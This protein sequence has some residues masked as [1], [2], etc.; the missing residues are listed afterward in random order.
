M[1]I[2]LEYESSLHEEAFDEGVREMISVHKRRAEQ[3]DEKAEWEKEEQTRKE[4]KEQDEE[5]SEYKTEEK[6][7]NEVAP[8]NYL[9]KKV[10]Y[11]VCLNTCG[12][13]RKFKDE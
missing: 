7:W 13:D 11:V 5:A 4:T 2:Q 10:S 8:A 6:T 9:K 1:A 3:E 12:Q